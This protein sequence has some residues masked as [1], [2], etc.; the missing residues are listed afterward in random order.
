MHSMGKPGDARLGWGWQ[1]PGEKGDTG[2]PHFHQIWAEAAQKR[3]W[4]GRG[5]DQSVPEE[6]VSWRG[7]G[8]LGKHSNARLHREP[9]SPQG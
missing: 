7:A 3:A 8:S 2:K 6:T 1:Y 5:T 4:G 9:N